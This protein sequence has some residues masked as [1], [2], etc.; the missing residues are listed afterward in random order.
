MSMNIYL[1]NS[2]ISKVPLFKKKIKT[3]ESLIFDVSSDQD[4]C[5]CLGRRG[6]IKLNKI[7]LIMVIVDLC[8]QSWLKWGRVLLYSTDLY[9]FMSD[10]RDAADGLH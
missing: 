6:L 1:T 7:E 5:R 9:L 10:D 3:L 2:S 8:V 4:N